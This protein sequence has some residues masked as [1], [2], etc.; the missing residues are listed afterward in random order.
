MPPFICAILSSLLIVSTPAPGDPVLPHKISHLPLQQSLYDCVQSTE[1]SFSRASTAYDQEFREV[2][3]DV[4][5]YEQFA[6][7]EN[8]TIVDYDSQNN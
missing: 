1:A 5:R 2:P 8:D 4:P 3:S 7:V 6:A